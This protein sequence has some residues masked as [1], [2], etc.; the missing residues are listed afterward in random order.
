[1]TKKIPFI[2][3]NNQ[4]SKKTNRIILHIPKTITKKT[5]L[6][7]VFERGFQFPYFGRN[8][9]ALNDC[10]NGFEWIKEKS[11]IMVFH[12]DLPQLSDKELH[13]YLDI[14][15]HCVNSW[16]TC[17]GSYVCHVFNVVFPESVEKSIYKILNT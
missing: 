4:P 5:D 2:F 3:S 16:R 9:D 12:T 17:E 6:F 8:W 11:E 7:D 10:L 13:I 14:L 1:M 15:L